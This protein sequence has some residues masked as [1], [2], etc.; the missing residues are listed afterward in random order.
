[1]SCMIDGSRRLSSRLETS[2]R[3][4]DFHAAIQTLPTAARCKR[5]GQLL[6]RGV[7]QA[8]HCSV[9]VPESSL[10]KTDSRGIDTLVCK[11]QLFH[12]SVLQDQSAVMIRLNRY[13][14]TPHG[15]YTWTA[16]IVSTCTD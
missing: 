4:L 11:Y 10:C 13:G 9:R 5:K 16:G 15:K 2:F 1:M 3:L 8:R 14:H 12:N 7:S 6:G